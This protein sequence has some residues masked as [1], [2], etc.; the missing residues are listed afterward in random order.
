MLPTVRERF[1]SAESVRE[2]ILAGDRVLVGYSG[3]ADSTAALH[4]LAQLRSSLDFELF[5]CHLHHGQRQ[6]ADEEQQCCEQFAEQLGVPI[7]VGRADVP[8]ISRVQKVGLEEA[9][10]LARQSFF[11]QCAIQF[12]CSKI[13]TA[14]TSDDQLETIILNIARGSGLT[15]LGGIG[16][17][18]GIMIRPFL[19]FSREELRDYCEKEEL[20]FHDDPSNDDERFSRVLV[21]KRVV[22]HLKSIN[23]RVAE[24]VQNLA[25]I[26]RAEDHYLNQV[27]GAVL[28]QAEIPI[29]P[30]IPWLTESV[31]AKFDPRFVIAQDPAI[32]ARAIRLAT[33][34]MGGLL[35]FDQTRLVL[36][37]LSR[38]ESGSITCED[39]KVILTYTPSELWV[40][41]ED[42]VEVSR[43]A[44]GVPGT[45]E[46]H[47]FGWK[48]EADFER[49][50]QENHLDVTLDWD[51]VKQPLHLRSARP[52]DVIQPIG[53]AAETNVLELMTKRKL[54]SAARRRLPMILDV[55]GPFWVPGC[56]LADRVKLTE[57]TT[58][59]LRLKFERM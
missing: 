8:T 17:H 37:A 11:R 56:A 49:G 10:R 27:A 33:E 36:N 39:A 6:E 9:G 50:P 26:V 5:A 57:S 12:Q 13:I 23:P 45:T 40:R 54:T 21:R 34:Y 42:E 18:D 52:A 55:S 15:G 19:E 28:A 31:E 3:G 47:V 48:I 46:G 14:H 20:W 1:L 22:P 29:N 25:Q 51:R 38:G 59:T 43:F 30:D 16:A 2:L 58:R 32:Q 35:N 44:V 24:H 53:R 4:L 7:M 41:A